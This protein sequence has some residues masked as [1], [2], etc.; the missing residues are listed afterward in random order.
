MFSWEGEDV[1]DACTDVAARDP[2]TYRIGMLTMAP[3]PDGSTFALHWFG[4]HPEMAQFLMRVEPRRWGVEMGELIAFK[5]RVQGVVTAIDVT[6][7]SE[8]H[9]HA[10][11]ELAAPHFGIAWWGSLEAL[12]EGRGHWPEN[13]LRKYRGSSPDTAPEPLANQETAE[14]IRFL[15]RE[16]PPQAPEDP[17]QEP[18]APGSKLQG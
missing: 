4:R 7:P 10:F 15:Q 8:E 16:F 2:R 11:N 17:D 14:F 3:W 1:V 13:L 12:K 6:G 18:Q 5:A 9:R